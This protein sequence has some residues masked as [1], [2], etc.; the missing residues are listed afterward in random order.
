LSQYYL[1]STFALFHLKEAIS[2]LFLLL[3]PSN[4]L[5]TVITAVML[6]GTTA[7]TTITTTESV[8]AHRNGQA[9]S[10]VN[11]CGNGVEGLK[12]GCQNTDS[13]I[14]GDNNYLALANTQRFAQEIE[15][16]PLMLTCE[17]CVASY[18]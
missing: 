3:L 18:R 4:P 2:I 14:Q 12:V 9:T 16:P 6:V 11:D 7:I 13:Q 15:E 1:Q 10:Q 8:F 5:T 17:G